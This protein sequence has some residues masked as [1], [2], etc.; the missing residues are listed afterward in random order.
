MTKHFVQLSFFAIVFVL[1]TNAANAQWMPTNGPGWGDIYALAVSQDQP[2]CVFAGTLD[3][4]VFLSTNNGT[5]WT[6]INSGFPANG[7][8]RSIAVSGNNIFAGT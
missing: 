5:N 7:D 3:N 2:G 4:G 6:E 1:F 8:V